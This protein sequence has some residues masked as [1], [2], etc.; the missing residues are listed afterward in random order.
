VSQLI[1]TGK[2]K[3]F[4]NIFGYFHHELFFKY[5]NQVISENGDKY[6]IVKVSQKSFN[7]F[8]TNFAYR[9]DYDKNIL[10][11]LKYQTLVCESQKLN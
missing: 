11:I 2:S 10:L 9:Y 8:K 7:W 1:A 5:Y 4:G 3:L 6:S